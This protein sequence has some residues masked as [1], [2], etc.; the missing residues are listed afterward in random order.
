MQ[1]SKSATHAA[2]PDG[3]LLDSFQ[4][5]YLK[6]Q[7]RG[8]RTLE[9][10]ALARADYEHRRRVA[11]IK[12]MRAKLA[13]LDPFIAPLAERGIRFGHRDI[14]AQDGGKV[15]RLHTVAFES[16]DD[17]LYAALLD[18]GF[19]EIAREDL[20]RSSRTSVVTL[21]HGRALVIKIDVFRAAPEAA[22]VSVAA[23]AA[24]VAA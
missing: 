4:L 3:P 5:G 12:A 23:P 16:A 13:L 14:H 10:L 18:L 17:R 2:Q 9:E 7:G 15:L 24:A 8:P 20:Y 21:K 22:A 11:E 19:R 6:Y 1:K